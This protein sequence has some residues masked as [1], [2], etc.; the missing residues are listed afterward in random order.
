MR[1]TWRKAR[2]ARRR[3]SAS[4]R[5]AFP[6]PASLARCQTTGWWQSR[7]PRCPESDAASTAHAHRRRD[8]ALARTGRSS[9]RSSVAGATVRRPLIRKPPPSGSEISCSEELRG[10][11]RLLSRS[12]IEAQISQP[13]RYSSYPREPS[14]M[15]GRPHKARKLAHPPMPRWAAPDRPVVRPT[16]ERGVAYA[17]YG[18][19]RV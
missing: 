3:T 9:S 7:R 4:H 10:L 6:R 14:P 2:Q 15:K 17:V 5:S 16:T 18:H 8:A 12:A 19:V 11:R 1:S 13:G